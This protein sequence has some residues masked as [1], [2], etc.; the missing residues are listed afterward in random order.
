MFP[1][2]LPSSL[3][4]ASSLLVWDASSSHLTLWWMLI[5]VVVF[6]PIVLTYTAW[7]FR[8]LRGPVTI[9]HIREDDKGLY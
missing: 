9:E 3:D 1:F 7:V 4:P 6:L 8:V 2:I 5:A